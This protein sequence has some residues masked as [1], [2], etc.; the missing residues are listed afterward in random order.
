MPL[1]APGPR[2]RRA[3]QGGR[4]CSSWA[5]RPSSTARWSTRSATRS[6]TSSATRWTTASSRRPS[7]S[8]R[9]SRPR[10]RSSIAARHAGRQHRH[11][12]QRRRPRDRPAP[13]SPIAP[14]SAGCITAA[15][16]DAVDVDRAIEL[17]FAPGFSTAEAT[18]DLSGRGVGM[19]AVRAD[20]RARRRGRR[21]LRAR[22]GARRRRSACRS[23]WRSS[24][25]PSSSR[26]ASGAFAHPA[27]PRRAHH[28]PRPTRWSAPSRP[29]EMLVLR[30][31]R[32]AAPGPRAD[33]RR[34]RH[35]R[36]RTPPTGTPSSSARGAQLR[37]GGLR[38]SAA[39]VSS[40]PVRCRPTPPAASRRAPRCSATGTIVLLARLR[41]PHQR[42]PAR[43]AVAPLPCRR[44]DAVL[45][46]SSSTPSASSRTSAPATPAR[47]CPRSSAAR[48]HRRPDRGRAPAS[49]RPSPSPAS[50]ASPRHGV[51]SCRSPATSSRSS[52][53]SS[54]GDDR[55]HLPAARHAEPAATPGGPMLGEVGNILGTNY[56][57]VLAQMAG[58]GARARPAAGLSTGQARRHPRRGAHCPRPG[59]RHRACWSRLGVRHRGRGLRALFLLV[60]GGRGV[61]LL[62]ERLGVGA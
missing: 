8:P 30:D 54:R 20:P 31:E 21:A 37:P 13:S 42:G 16:E 46:T 47:R 23:P 56:I 38:R 59:R 18:G 61:A 4:R 55:G 12:G 25:V 41:R 1:P 5:R 14:R 11:L 48:R 9:A 34:A 43:S 53:C 27:P 39:S 51:S 15:D 19:D 35:R 10:A 6:C 32:P 2:R 36:R 40:S 26:P 60:P 58:H 3:R 62:L 52:S 29:A 28:A 24:D 22:R 50:P 7:A 17:L 57:N 44:H 49:A 45:P 33:P